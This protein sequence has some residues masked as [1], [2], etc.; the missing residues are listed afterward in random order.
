MSISFAETTRL[1]AIAKI[2]KDSSC[3]HGSRF[4]GKDINLLLKFLKSWPF[5]L[6]LIRP[7]SVEELCWESDEECE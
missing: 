1:G 2:L 3:C 5:N 6:C 4:S 7:V